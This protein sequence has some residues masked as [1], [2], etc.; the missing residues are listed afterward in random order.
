MFNKKVSAVCRLRPQAAYPSHRKRRAPPTH[1][2]VGADGLQTAETFLFTS[3]Y[4]EIIIAFGWSVAACGYGFGAR[5]R[6]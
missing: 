5:D 1:D 4:E 6:A 2:C 3:E